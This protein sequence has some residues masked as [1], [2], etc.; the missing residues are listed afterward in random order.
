MFVQLKKKVEND[1]RAV[2]AKDIY[3]NKIKSKN[4]FKEYPANFDELSKKIL[5][6]VPDTGRMRNAFMATD[7]KGMDKTLFTLG[8]KNY[9]QSDFA[10]Y[11]ETL[12]RGKL[13]GPRAVVISDAYNGYQTNVITDFQEHKLEV[14]N[15]EFGNLMREYRDGILLFELMDRN[16]WSKAS[17]DT[18][19][20]Q[21]FF[22][23]RRS[24]YMWEPGFEGSIF[25]TKNKATYD[26]LLILI[27]KKF[28]DEQIIKELNT[29]NAPDRV[30]IQRGH[31]EFA[32]FKDASKEELL[33]N[34]KKMITQANGTIK[35]IYARQIYQTPTNKSLDDARGYVVAEY[36]DF[37]EKQWN[38]KMRH[39]YPLKVNDQVFKTMVGK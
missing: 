8:G 13:S 38:E 16:V 19:G 34:N 26:T 32:K 3:F 35:L 10:K 30:A 24:K 14:E 4:G 27:D 12:T 17:K 6:T 25:T 22:E 36:Q 2:T 9:L 33:A 1:G 5:A 37:L 29:S 18:V 15:S 23:T 31:Y 11:L 21:A 20:L 28:T 39:D 7:Y